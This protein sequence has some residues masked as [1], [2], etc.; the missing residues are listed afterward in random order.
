MPQRLDAAL[1][2]ALDALRAP[3]APRPGAPAPPG[4]RAEL[5][6][7][8]DAQLRS[9]C[10][11]LVTREL[12]ARGRGYYSIASA[13][14]EADAAVAAALRPTDPALLHYRSGAFYAA[15]AQ[16]VGGIDP[17]RDVLLG[18]MGAADDPVSGGRHKVLGRH[19]LAVVPQTSTIASHLPRAV[20][21]AFALGRARRLGVEPAFPADSVVVC[22]LGD[23]SVNHS[24][25]T[26]AVNAAVQTAYRGL[27]MPLLLVCEDN[28]LG[29]STPTPA[30]WVEHALGYRPGLRYVHVRGT[31]TWEVLEAAREL[32]AWVRRH[33]RPALLH[34]DTVRFLGHAGT[35]VESAYRAPADVAA[36]L[37][38]D[39]LAVHAHDLVAHGLADADEL[40]ARYDGVLERNRAVAA[41]VGHL[42]QLPDAVAV[43][44]PLTRTAPD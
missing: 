17:V 37:A 10:A 38:R 19:E 4:P 5:L 14:H 12:R 28:G 7:L 21:L 25:A 44:G 36:D 42:P 33:R 29:I 30:G 8:F 9:R 6:D 41:A 16:Q 31:G 34:L 1:R 13:G 39:P 35:D 20:G 43:T 22:S 26:G 27:P 32:A 11:D 15:R 40:L 2:A 23:A 3:V 24:T 18:V